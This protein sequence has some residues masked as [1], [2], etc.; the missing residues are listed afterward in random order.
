M[1]VPRKAID[2]LLA[3]PAKHERDL[4]R[5]RYQGKGGDRGYGGKRTKSMAKSNVAVGPH[6]KSG[7]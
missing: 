7:S 4:A 5:C 3:Q 6:P 2:K 1:D